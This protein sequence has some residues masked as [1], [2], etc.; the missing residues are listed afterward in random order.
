MGL[1]Q[2]LMAKGYF[3][4]QLPPGFSTE[5]FSTELGQFSAAWDSTTQIATSGEKYSVARSSYFRRSTMVVNPIG[6]YF[7]AKEIDAYWKKIQTHYRKSKLSRSVPAV[8]GTLRAINLPKFGDLY[9]EKI[10]AS[11]GYKYALVT[12]VSS[13]FPTIYTHT[14]PWA[15][16]GKTL[17]KS[18][19]GPQNRT[20]NYFGNILDSKSMLIQ[21]GQTI[22]LPIG[23]DTSHI[24]AEIIAVAIDKKIQGYWRKWPKG[25]RYVDD[26][27]FFF[28][29]KDEAEKALAVV[30]KAARDF[31]LQISPAKTR[32]VLTK[33]LVE[34]SWKYRIKKLKISSVK[35]KQ[36]DEL[37]HY[38]ESLFSF[39]KQYG[40]ESLVK[41]GLKRL[42]S[43]IVKL[44][45]WQVLEAYLLKCGYSFPNT[46]Q[47][48]A[49]ILSTYQHHGYPL[50]KQAIGIFCN[51]LLLSTAASDHD[52]EVSWLLWICKELRL[53]VKKPAAKEIERMGSGVCLLLL[54]DLHHM[55]LSTSTPDGNLLATY[56]NT[57]VLNSERWLVAYE[58]GRRKWL[59]NKN[60][61]FILRHAFFGPLLRAKVGF[62]D[63]T[64][65]IPPAF[66]F[67]FRSPIA[68]N[69]EFDFDTDADIEDRFEFDS[70][71]EEYFDSAESHPS[72]DESDHEDSSDDEFG[73]D[74][75]Y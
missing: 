21:D 44:S 53:S 72:E 43:N 66:D 36:R 31:E 32:V 16:H 26:F 8:G 58:A 27:Y 30:S 59:G 33:E 41:Y 20:P 73:D 28:A 54:L 13:F 39:E 63:D 46:L 24:L 69:D 15:L 4:V 10:V 23:P 14:I 18:K 65:R 74:N 11:A 60:T 37:H 25:F 29:A 6:F 47:V 50:N 55:G 34:E 5:S 51:N 75:D 42:A 64:R 7:L 3:P 57:D 70:F 9:E 22:G 38:F 2:D 12:D 62:Y 35:K 48:I 45:N 1:L 56:A 19:K 49:H 67:K 71:D 17:A 52:G 61:A 68:E 40:D